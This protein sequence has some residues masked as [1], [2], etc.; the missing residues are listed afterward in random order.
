M[1]AFVSGNI[2]EVKGLGTMLLNAAETAEYGIIGDKE[3]T[4]IK[5]KYQDGF[6]EIRYKPIETIDKWK[7]ED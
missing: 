6:I 5:I 2:E 3:G 4:D 7:S 1:N